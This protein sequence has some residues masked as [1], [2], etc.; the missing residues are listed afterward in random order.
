M[1]ACLC[2]Y[3]YVYIYIYIYR[4]IQEL[5]Q[6]KTKQILFPIKTSSDDDSWIRHDFGAKP[7]L[8]FSQGAPAVSYNTTR[9]YWNVFDQ[10][11]CYICLDAVTVLFW[12]LFIYSLFSA[13]ESPSLVKYVEV[14]FE[15]K[16]RHPISRGNMS[17]DQPC[18]IHCSCRF[19]YFSNFH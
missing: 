6:K 9:L 15:I 16:P 7:S 17:V 8:L 2:V 19:P 1:Y 11:E 18:L 5:P 12:I 13:G 10:Y 4:I 14:E 3:I